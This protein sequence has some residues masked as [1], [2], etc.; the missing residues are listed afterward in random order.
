MAAVCAAHRKQPYL[1][2]GW[3]YHQQTS[4]RGWGAATPR[5]QEDAVCDDASGGVPY[6]ILMLCRLDDGC[7]EA[8][9]SQLETCTRQP[10]LDATAM[11]MM[12]RVAGRTPRRG[13]LGHGFE[14]LR[15]ALARILGSA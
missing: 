12:L 2:D 3:R 7:Y 11:T 10:G 1:F 15:G 14:T 8:L 13:G 5:R 9:C 4:R 6:L